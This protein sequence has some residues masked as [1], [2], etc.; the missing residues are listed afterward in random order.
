MKKILP[1]DKNVVWKNAAELLERRGDF[2][3]Q[4][5]PQMWRKKFPEGAAW[6]SLQSA[7]VRL[8]LKTDS[9]KA[10]LRWKNNFPWEGFDVFGEVFCDGEFCG[11]FSRNP[12]EQTRE[13]FFTAPEG[14]THLWQI[15][16][17][18]CAEIA[19]ESILLDEKA[20]LFDIKEPQKKL[21]L[22]YGSSITQGFNST[23]ATRTWPC[24]A[25]GKL[26]VDFYNL[27]FGG[28]AFYEKAVAEYIASRDDWDYLT[29]ESGTNTGGGY[30]PASSFKNTF[31]VFLDTIREKHSEKP[32]LCFT[33]T[34]YLA[35][36]GANKDVK[37]PA[38]STFEEYR[39]VVREVVGARQA[40][41]R[42]LY[43][44]EGR[45]WVDSEDLL[46][47]QIH[48][49]DEGMKRIGLGVA[50]TWKNT[51]MTTGTASPVTTLKSP[52]DGKGNRNCRLTGDST[53]S[54]QSSR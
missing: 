10:G 54:S 18:W 50:H 40:S 42:N 27:G 1:V 28:A 38:G 31:T 43:L 48:P 33:S 35:M 53:S 13:D 7:N 15:H 16:F 32:I 20:E 4:R 14:G 23:S 6:R 47:D 24:I 12:V 36:D 5:V 9:S 21:M 25:A 34:L 2:R 8:F 3:I 45:A 37:N 52:P 19:I 11:K 29:I 46:A 22:C 30:E 26:G 49:N 39:D 41:D 17:P 44:A 51:V